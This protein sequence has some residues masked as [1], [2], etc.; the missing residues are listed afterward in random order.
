VTM[1]RDGQQGLRG[2]PL[3]RQRYFKS[4]DRLRGQKA[5]L[6][7]GYQPLFPRE[8]SRWKV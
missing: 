8:Q 2:S 6:S 5:R 3:G 4:P 1:I 7:H